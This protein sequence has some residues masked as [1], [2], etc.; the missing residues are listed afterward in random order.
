M[1][2]NRAPV[3][4]CFRNYLVYFVLYR[5]SF[6]SARSD[7]LAGEAKDLPGLVLQTQISMRELERLIEAVQKQWPWRKHIN[8]TNPRL[9][10]AAPPTR[11]LPSPRNFAR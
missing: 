8:P 9:L 3:F 2:T 7:A 5:S 4:L 6:P 11:Q 1:F 10:R